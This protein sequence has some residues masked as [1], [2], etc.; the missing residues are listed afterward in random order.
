MK[1]QEPNIKSEQFRTHSP[2]SAQKIQTPSQY[3]RQPK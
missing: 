1:Q 3:L 2:S